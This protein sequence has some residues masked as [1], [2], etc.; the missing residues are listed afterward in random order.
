MFHASFS[1][2]WLIFR[3]SKVSK[4]KFSEEENVF[5]SALNDFA[6]AQ[7]IIKKTSIQ[8]IYL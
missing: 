4:A 6:T 8:V 3:K 7:G 1:N 2:P 5:F